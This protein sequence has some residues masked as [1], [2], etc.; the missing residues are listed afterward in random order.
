VE[1]KTDIEL[2]GLARNGDK[3]AFGILVERYQTVAQRF[4]MRTVANND[5]A[6]D[7][8][9]EA[10]LQTYLSLNNLRDPAR[11]KSWLLGIVL[12]V[13]RH[14]I[15]DQKTAFFSIEAMTGGLQ[16]D[17]IAF[18]DVSTSPEQLSEEHELH[19]IVMDTINE[20]EPVD[21]EATLLF[22][23][24]QMSLREIGD[25]LGISTGAVK[26]R[27]YRVRQ[28][29]KAS[30]LSRHPEIMPVEQRRKIMVKVTVA[31]VVKQELKNE[32]GQPFINYVI[33]LQDE[34]GKCALP[35]WV[36][37][38]EG[39]SIAMGIGE[40]ATQRPM[41]YDFFAGLLKAINAKIV[42]VR[43]EAL[44]ETTFY[45]VVKISC[46][47]TSGEIDA[48]PSDALALAVRTGSPV[49]VS[50]EVLKVAGMDIPQTA[51]K[52]PAR[53]GVESIL[54]EIGDLQ[55]RAQPSH[56]QHEEITKA[57][58]ELMATVFNTSE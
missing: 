46:G 44:K 32:K 20:L 49:F 13:C 16:F 8:V 52:P 35:I 23:Y 2:V 15:R 34:A 56:V 57:R 25:I 10:M 22:Y 58:E 28:R 4:A 47:K 42:E 55:Q 21:R 33:M 12:N 1:E 31:D 38:F 7:L 11:F 9:Q 36:G 50:E 5:C 39:Q 19:S 26:V 51:K 17:A 18:T 29:L 45:A 30:L 53:A 54:K 48:R 6:Q 41:T 24:D 3:N 40:Y 14:Y 37:P 43:I 27:L